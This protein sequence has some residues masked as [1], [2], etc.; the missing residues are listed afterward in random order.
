MFQREAV[1]ILCSMNCI[2]KID[3]DKHSKSNKNKI[4]NGNIEDIKIKYEKYIKGYHDKIN[5][6]DIDNRI[7]L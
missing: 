4:D 1:L 7:E 6:I 5:V 2:S 3:N